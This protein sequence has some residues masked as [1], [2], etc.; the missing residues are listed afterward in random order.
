MGTTTRYHPKHVCA[1]TLVELL[2]VIGII[3]LLI[4]ILLPT[5]HKARLAALNTDCASQLR[6]LTTACQ[7]YLNEQRA[8]PESLYIPAFEGCAPSTIQ[9]RLLNELG[10]YLKWPT[11]QGTELTTD[12]PKIADC[13]YRSQLDLFQQPNNSVG[14]TYW[15]TGYVYCGPLNDSLNLTGVILNSGHIVSAK[16]THR[17]V[18]W[19]DTLMYS[20]NGTAPIG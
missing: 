7:M 3:S 17:G 5:I 20:A 15:I 13:P 16:G 2:V 11:F 12:L 14:T 19:A 6:Q 10:P 8:Y 18:L 1:F 4:S 9:P